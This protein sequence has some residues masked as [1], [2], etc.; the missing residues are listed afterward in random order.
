MHLPGD[1]STLS[2][3]AELGLLVA[4]ALEPCRL[5]PQGCE[6]LA[7]LADHQPERRGRDGQAGDPDPVL[8]LL[9]LPAAAPA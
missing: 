4:L 8:E 6:Q 2:G 5:L 7:A 9:R 3:G 1:A